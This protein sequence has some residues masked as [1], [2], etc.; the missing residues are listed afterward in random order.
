MD[1]QR[2]L[3]LAAKLLAMDPGSGCSPEE[4]SNAAAKLAKLA[5]ENNLEM[6]DIQAHAMR[7]KIAAEKAGQPWASPEPWVCELAYAVG[8][9][10]RCTVVSHG[11]GRGGFTIVGEETEAALC[12][13]FLGYLFETFP[14]MATA[15]KKTLDWVGNGYGGEAT[16][17]YRGETWHVHK[18]AFMAGAT[19]SVVTRLRQ[20]Y[21][22][23]FADLDAEKKAKMGALIVV[24]DGA[25]KAK[26]EALFP[27]M[28]TAKERAPLAAT[29]AS[30]AGY[31]AGEKV[32]LSQGLRHEESRGPRIG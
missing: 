28:K 21:D 26:L 18:Q 32:P 24:K 2:A 3:D 12:R 25:I 15:Y 16:R 4:A 1:R 7:D 30:I 23:V 29:E 17:T 14:K 11:K 19:V 27:K 9:A 22:N 5:A 13:Y 6:L 20:V 31:K 8:F 10:L